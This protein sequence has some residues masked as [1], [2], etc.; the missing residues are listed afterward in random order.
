MRNQLR[1]ALYLLL[2]DA[3]PKG[4]VA[5]TALLPLVFA[6]TTLIPGVD[7]VTFEYVLSGAVGAANFGAS[8]AMVGLVAHD[9]ASGGLRAACLAPRGRQRYVVSRAVLAG[10]VSVALM[11][12][13]VVFSA[14]LLVFPGVY[15]AYSDA[16]GELVGV[17]GA[18]VLVAWAYATIAT[19]LTW[20]SRRE[21]GMGGVFLISL[22]VS[23]G[24]LGLLV[25][26]LPVMVAQLFSQELGSALLDG[27]RFVLLY[28]LVESFAV[29]DPLR[30]VALPLVYLV[31]ASALSCR[32]WARRAV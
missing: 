16:L 17:V 30:S 5:I 4:A 15:V 9:L 8:F 7:P 21:R 22:A 29:V 25:Q 3:Y 1:A 19:L 14:V 13:A 10:V 24:I 18:R 28:P 12:W 31:A 26:T 27:L 32:L 6:L 2:H 23:A 20:V 11:L